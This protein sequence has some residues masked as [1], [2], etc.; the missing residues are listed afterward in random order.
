MSEKCY[1]EEL[2]RPITTKY[3]AD[4]GEEDASATKVIAESF[5][6]WCFPNKVAASLRS[7]S[8]IPLFYFSAIGVLLIISSWSPRA[9]ALPLSIAANS[10]ADANLSTLR[11][12][13]RVPFSTFSSNFLFFKPGGRSAEGYFID[14]LPSIPSPFSPA[15]P[16]PPKFLS[17]SLLSTLADLNKG[18]LPPPTQIRFNYFS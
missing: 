3:W 11:A 10:R 14:M 5:L 8:S 1:N 16:A 9:A 13:R 4:G 7:A 17:L 15:P 18:E 6:A 2:F 12:T